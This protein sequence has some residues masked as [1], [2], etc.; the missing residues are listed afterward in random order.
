LSAFQLLPH[1]PRPAAHEVPISKVA[2]FY[3]HGKATGQLADMLT[4]E[5]EA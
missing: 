1:G 2:G 3:A 5:G 4:S